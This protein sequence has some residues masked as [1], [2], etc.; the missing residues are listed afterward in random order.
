[1]ELVS[2]EVVAAVMEDL[3][4]V[5]RGM[6]GPAVPTA[7]TS[8]TLSVHVSAC[9]EFLACP[10]SLRLTLPGIPILAGAERVA[11]VLAS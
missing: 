9:M 8:I 1:M 10:G 6:E 11:N 3:V 7:P 4:E 5:T 2:E